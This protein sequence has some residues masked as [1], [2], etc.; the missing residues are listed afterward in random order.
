MSSVQSLL[1]SPHLLAASAAKVSETAGNRFRVLI[2][3]MHD[4]FGAD[5]SSPV[6][7]ASAPGRTELSGNHTDHN[8]GKVLA[9][10]ID[11]DSIAAAI[12]RDDE[13]VR[14]SSEGFPVAEISLADLEPR[15]AEQESTAALIR[16]VAAGFRRDNYRVGG[17]NATVSSTV[18]PGSGLSSSASFEVL[19]GVILDAMYN[20]G[21]VGTTRIAQIGQFAENHYF[22]KPSGL[23]DQ[24]ACAT[25]GAVSI[26]FG[27][28]GEPKIDRIDVSFEDAGLALL[29]VDTGA[30]HADLTDEYA[31][32][33]SDMR[34]IAGALG[35][36]VLRDIRPQ[37]FYAA[38]PELRR[39]LGDR[40]VARAIHFFDEN[41]RVEQMIDALQRR[42]FGEYLALMA[43][44]G[45]SSGLYLQNCVPVSNP[46]EQGVVVALALTEHYFLSSGIRIGVDGS[47]RVHGGG[48]A[49]TIQ[50]LLPGDHVERY[51]SYI[52]D[53]LG[54]QAVTGLSIRNSGAIAVPA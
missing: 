28:P 44:S 32:I 27:D 33:P 41:V 8:N 7:L 36:E 43:D 29:V 16:G 10:S 31:A 39:T 15:H 12:A 52:T 11:L 30:N 48:F 9:A 21:D 50:V 14:V 42:A 53:H 40:S 3:R 23:M 2:E 5:S 24:V 34:S 47:C 37:D 17:F 25:G 45:R 26:D 1:D 6:W 22:G 19:V 4:E 54:K 20:H 35:G 13:V 18:L 38:L 49:G 46:G 51:E